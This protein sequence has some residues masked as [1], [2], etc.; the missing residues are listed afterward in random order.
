MTNDERIDIAIRLIEDIPSINDF[1]SNK[2]LE[3]IT[4]KRLLSIA[5]ELCAGVITY[6]VDIKYDLKEE[7]TDGK[8]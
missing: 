4:K 2:E 6:L 8:I 7:E 5:D 1:V 3:E